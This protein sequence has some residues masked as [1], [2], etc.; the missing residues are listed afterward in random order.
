MAARA[1]PALAW[2][3]DIRGPGG[4]DAGTEH[5]VPLPRPLGQR[6]RRLRLRLRGRLRRR[7]G[8]G[9]AAPAASARH[10]PGGGTRRRRLG[11]RSRQRHAHRRGAARAGRA[12]PGDTGPGLA[13]T[14]P[15]G[16]RASPVLPGPGFPRLLRLRARPPA[17][18]RV[19]DLPRPGGR[20][21][22]VGGTVD[23]GPL[24]GRPRRPGAGRDRLAAHVIWGFSN[25]LLAF[26]ESP[27]PRGPGLRPPGSAVRTRCRV[28]ARP[29]C[30]FHGTPSLEGRPVIPGPGRRA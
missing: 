10:C 24:G 15:R 17:R 12:G 14:G 6:K 7:P 16:G 21:G 22:A 23:A 13:G 2:K 11:S 28:P 29:V 30:E 18:R 5:P 9:H 25:R 26:R 1:G 20:P 4:G 3:H 8:D 19:A 27:L